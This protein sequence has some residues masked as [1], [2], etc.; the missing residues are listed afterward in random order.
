MIN[1]FT[2]LAPNSA[3]RLRQRLVQQINRA[4]FRALR[5]SPRLPPAGAALTCQGRSDGGGAQWLSTFSVI[6]FARHYRIPFAHTPLACVEHGH[7]QGAAWLQAWNGLFDL[8][9]AGIPLAAGAAQ[10]LPCHNLFQA[11]RELLASAGP[12]GLRSLH[13]AHQ[14]TNLFP[15]TLAALRPWMRQAYRPAAN[16]APPPLPLDHTL[17]VH[18]RR[19]DVTATG[20]H[21]E[22]FSSASAVL[23]RCRAI[24]ARWPHLRQVLLLS[25]TADPDLLALTDQGFVLD[26]EHDVFTHLHWMSHA[27]GLVIARSALSYLAAMLNPALIFAE[28]FEHPPLPGWVPLGR[29]R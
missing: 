5:C 4:R 26:S 20:P 3:R 15:A 28:P 12:P 17:V 21:R 6:A 9:A 13:H 25:A 24:Q 27:A 23:A 29:S 16:L 14:F 10:P 1:P 18:V 2:P 11:R 19:G 7:G 8:Q 22:R